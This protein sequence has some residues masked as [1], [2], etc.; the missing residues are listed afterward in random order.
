MKNEKKKRKKKKHLPTSLSLDQAKFL[1]RKGFL[2][3]RDGLDRE[4]RKRDRNIW[5]RSETGQTLNIYR[6]RHLIRSRCI[7]E[8]SRTKSRQ[9]E[10]V[11]TAKL[12][13]WIEMV[14]S[15]YRAN[16][17]FR[18]MAQWIGLSI[19]R[20]EENPGKFRQKR[21]VSRGI[22]LLSSQCRANRDEVF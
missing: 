1:K 2:V 13:R 8:V 4:R 19:Q 16:R 11:S 22:E 21:I 5:M 12:L 14:L 17:E 20:Y 10:V 18:N 9:I 3:K 6:I 15:F 7:E